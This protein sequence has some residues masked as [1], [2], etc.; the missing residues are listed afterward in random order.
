MQGR[1]PH[2]VTSVVIRSISLNISS[3]RQQHVSIIAHRAGYSPLDQLD[4]AS[5]GDLR[6]VWFRALCAGGRQQVTP[7]VYDGVLSCRT[8]SAGTRS[9]RARRSGLHRRPHR[10]PRVVRKRLAVKRG[11]RRR[12]VVLS[13]LTRRAR[14]R[15]GGAF[16]GSRGAGRPCRRRSRRLAAVVHAAEVVAAIGVVGGEIGLEGGDF[17]GEV[18]LHARDLDIDGV[19]VTYPLL[20]A[21][22]RDQ[23]VPRRAG[24]Q[25]VRAVVRFAWTG[26]PPRGSRP[27]WPAWSWATSPTPEASGQASWSTGSTPDPATGSTWVAIA[28]R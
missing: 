17:A 23:R 6:L 15:G 26:G 8:T 12:P 7:L 14:A 24:Q 4:R 2:T 13:S 19:E 25:P 22:V 16:P 10:Q 5:V 18:G 28:M 3:F 9:T 1:P 11:C 27:R 21:D 20:W